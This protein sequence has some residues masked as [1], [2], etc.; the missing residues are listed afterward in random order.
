MK[1]SPGLR[2]E[3]ID[4]S[5]LHNCCFVFR[6][7]LSGV[8]VPLSDSAPNARRFVRLSPLFPRVDPYLAL[9]LHPRFVRTPEILSFGF[10]SR[11]YHL[12][13]RLLASWYLC[14]LQHVVFLPRNFYAWTSSLPRMIASIE[15]RDIPIPISTAVA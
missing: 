11:L 13:A 4:S 8:R 14:L 3:G 12:L 1:S 2:R 9:L 7:H 10:G 5:A 6:A 15:G